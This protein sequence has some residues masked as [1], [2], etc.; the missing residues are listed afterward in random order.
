M[1]E[2]PART[3]LR[4][5]IERIERLE[6]SKAEIASDIK[7]VYSEADGAGFDKKILRKVIAIRKDPDYYQQDAVLD[8]YLG[9]L[10][11]LAGGD[12]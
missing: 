6:E 8:T 9:A 12:E 1:T 3:Q 11:M 10:G 7:D 4:A 2:L 5:F